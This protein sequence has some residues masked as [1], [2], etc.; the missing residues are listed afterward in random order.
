MKR[1][2]GIWKQHWEWIVFIFLAFMIAF[3]GM[4][5]Q[6]GYQSQQ[7]A[8]AAGVTYSIS[9]DAGVIK[10]SGEIF[11]LRRT[12]STYSINAEGE[13]P[14]Y[15]TY[16]WEINE[17]TNSILAF[18]GSSE[19][20]KECSNLSQKVTIQ[21]KDTAKQRSD[22]VQISVTGQSK[23]ASGKIINSQII[24][25]FF[26]DV[27]FSISEYLDG[28][29]KTS[30]AKMLKVYNNDSN[31]KRLSLFLEC[32][33]KLSIGNKDEDGR[34]LKLVFGEG[35]KADWIS[36]NESIITT[37]KDEDGR[38]YIYAVSSG[39]TTLKVSYKSENETQA[40][41][42][43]ID[44]YVKPKVIATSTNEEG[45][46]ITVGEVGGVSGA[47]GAAA[48]TTSAAMEL[49]NND[50]IKIDGPANINEELNQ[51]VSW[52]ILK[53]AGENFVAICDSKGN[54][55]KD[56]GDD[57][58]LIVRS[59]QKSYRMEAKAGKYHVLFFPIGTYRNFDDA[60]PG[61]S[62]LTIDPITLLADIRSPFKDKIISLSLGSSYQIADAL[63]LAFNDLGSI[64]FDYEGNS[65][66]IVNVNNINN[67]PKKGL[68][69]AKKLGRAIITVRADENACDIPGIEKGGI[70][71]DDGKG[72]VIKITVLV[73]DTFALNITQM[74]LAVGASI[75]LHGV[76]GS[77]T[78]YPS[79]QFEWKIEG[80]GGE[81][82]VQISSKT[83]RFTTVTG[84]KETPR[85][86]EA[87]VTLAW[88]DNNNK[89]WVASCRITVTSSSTKF[90]IT[91]DKKTLEVG[92]SCLIET[93]VSGKQNI[94]WVSSN[95]SIVTVEAQLGS[96]EAKLSAKG[97][98]TAVITAINRD[99]D[100]YAT[101]IITVNS[102]ITSLSIDKGTSYHS[103]LA[104]PYI[105]FGAVYK[106]DNS[107]STNM[108]WDSSDEAV[109]TIDSTGTVTVKKLGTTT[110]S[111]KPEY[112]PNGLLAQCVLTIYDDPIT[113]IKTKV[114]SLNMLKG[115]TYTADVTIAPINPTDPTLTWST[116]NKSVATVSKAGEIKAVGVGTATIMIEGGK[117]RPALIQVTVADKLKS[118]AF[119]EKSVTMLKGEQKKLEL[120]FN[121]DVNTNHTVTF[122][123]SD[124]S[125]V[126]VD[127][128]GNIKAVKEGAAMII[129]TS[130]ELGTAGAV[131]CMVT[132][133]TPP[134]LLEDFTLDPL[135]K[136]I[137]MGE[138]FEITPIFKPS[139][140]SSTDLEFESL[141]PRVATVSP[142]GTVH[143]ESVGITYIQCT[144]TV[145]GLVDMC[146]VTVETPVKVD[147]TPKKQTIL[148][149]KSFQ[150]KATITPKG[151]DTPLL[152]KSSDTKIA[153]VTSSGKV[154]GKKAGTCT[155][156]CSMPEYEEEVT[157]EVK[158]EKL[159]TNLKLNKSSIRMNIGSTYRLKKTVTT[160]NTTK[161]KVQFTSNN[162]KVAKVGLTSGN[163]KAKKLGSAVITAKTMDAIHA[164]AKCRVTVI[165][166]VTSI[167]LNKTYATC[168]IGRNLKLR[169]TVKPSN[170]T[171]KKIKWSSSDRNVAA[172]TGK[173]KVTAY[174]AGEAY[175]TVKTTDGSNR[176][177]RCLVRVLEVVPTSSILI[178]Q[179]NMTMKRG[180]SAKLTYTIVPH[181]HSDKVKIASDN[182]RVAT[183][184]N[185]GKVKAVGTGTA[186]ITITAES[187]ITSTATIHVVE[188]NKSRVRMRQYDTETLL[189][190]GTSDQITW[191]SGNNRI[192]TVVGGKVT[193][194]GLGTTYVYAYVNGCKMAC[195]VD[196]VSVN[197]RR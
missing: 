162:K 97:P 43:Q 166:R 123:T 139:D 78:E 80:Q 185:S 181:N 74:N 33:K 54:K 68:V 44:V 60:V 106:P 142:E 137:K 4:V 132:V 114:S 11:E 183:V 19:P 149:G 115:D 66:T 88:T 61:T 41:E 121:P 168:Y 30:G 155:I 34:F 96:A 124:K 13:L 87:I 42:D 173:G 84:K 46:T 12:K 146:M 39:K 159:R 6:Q 158:V 17:P 118:I 2:V 99:N 89:I 102:P 93:N 156:T 170:A 112:N 138:Y 76:I 109:A 50:V 8:Q 18:E 175:I 28:D 150:I 70:P 129:A 5:W 192:A 47:S 133:E 145:S 51:R 57:A 69:T 1:I 10:K 26:I 148:I 130:E 174:S 55:H 147:I 62:T 67:D 186:T 73:E 20:I 120:T 135:E 65:D 79:D 27:K 7:S 91:P 71:S 167:S 37:G 126:T 119:K 104:V 184:T 108:I 176:K 143:G 63:N 190:H 179:S 15:S 128:N 16:V 122:T 40:S 25:S 49:N 31:D 140:V 35:K 193:G 85:D 86:T 52:V 81:D 171:I 103:S 113:S 59:D 169:A 195:R 194:R 92:E 164:T 154:T 117:A 94:L 116:N 160:N 29:L 38:P 172:V 9:D 53:E 22:P 64:T 191:Y 105:F 82:Y 189:V 165:R 90:I 100:V 75:D 107:T 161:P 77:D 23:D 101:C 98:G 32:G 72:R 111:V 3:L 36:G 95:T 178:S 110:I 125:I 144:E 196:V 152:W 197:A 182:R 58:R 131:T 141:D 187:G 188:M 163:I 21:V 48:V 83:G 177:A 24:V 136:T 127:K 14:S 134:V 157:C 153:T 56:Y 151:V 45:E 180:D